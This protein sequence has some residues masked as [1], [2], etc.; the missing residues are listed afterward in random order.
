MANIYGKKYIIVGTDGILARANSVRYI[1]DPDTVDTGSLVALDE[2]KKI[3]NTL[4]HTTEIGGTADKN[5]HIPTLGENGKLSATLLPSDIGNNSVQAISTGVS[6]GSF[7]HLS[8]NG[9]GILVCEPADVSVLSDLRSCDGFVLESA[10]NGEEVQVW[11]EGKNT[12][13]TALDIGATYF[14]DPDNPGGIT[15]IAPRGINPYNGAIQR[16]GKAV[17]ATTLVF[18][19]HPIIK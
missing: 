5:G 16:V 6:A 12:M 4:L 11:L 15:A 8:Q 14:I 13:L 17:S 9:S 2:T 10:S 3:D 7:V 19:A 1:D 18:E